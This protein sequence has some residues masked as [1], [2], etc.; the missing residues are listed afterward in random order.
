MRLVA[1]NRLSETD[2]KNIAEL[3]KSLNNTVSI[4][5]NKIKD[6][7]FFSQYSGR[8]SIDAIKISQKSWEPYYRAWI[9]L[10][11]VLHPQADTRVLQ[12]CLLRQRLDSVTLFLETP[13]ADE[14]LDHLP[15]ESNGKP[16]FSCAKATTSAERSI[17]ADAVLS[18]KDSELALDYESALDRILPCDP[19]RQEL[20][21][22]QRQWLKSLAKC[23]G[24]KDCL[25][26]RYEQRIH[27]LE[28]RQDFVGDL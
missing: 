26:Q 5:T 20:V 24:R 18:K 27:A 12:A 4:S 7:E 2:D 16:S 11:R 22:A 28:G 14:R 25:L 8:I 13:N 3:Q 23:N 6:S 19:K 21:H 9:N 1:E 17:C 15:A 10:Y